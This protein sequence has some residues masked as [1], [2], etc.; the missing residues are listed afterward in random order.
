MNFNLHG[1]DIY[2]WSATTPD[3]PKTFGKFTLKLISNR[4][5]KIYP[6]PAPEI[7]LLDWPRC[8]YESEEVVTND[9]IDALIAEITKAGFSWNKCQ[10]LHRDDE[11]NNL[12]S[13]PY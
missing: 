9:E 1:V 11:G 5:T 2:I 8:R 6:G 13:Q 10:K 3:V 4:G 7:D 12:Y